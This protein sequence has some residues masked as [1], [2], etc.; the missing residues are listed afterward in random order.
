[1]SHLV[2]RSSYLARELDHIGAISHKTGCSF[3]CRNRA[4]DH[5]A[6][7]CQSVEAGL[8]TQAPYRCPRTVW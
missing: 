1:M 4:I 8:R 3:H 2:N 5:V 7:R 6:S